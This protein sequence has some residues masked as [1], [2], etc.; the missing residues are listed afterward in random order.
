MCRIGILFFI[1]LASNE[2][3]EG[4]AKWR[5]KLKFSLSQQS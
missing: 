4:V 1:A 5:E 3:V 2:K